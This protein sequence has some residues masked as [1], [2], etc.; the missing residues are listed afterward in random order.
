MSVCNCMFCRNKLT[1]CSVHT[2]VYRKTDACCEYT[3]VR[4]WLRCE[5]AAPAGLPAPRDRTSAR[6]LQIL[7]SACGK[8]INSAIASCVAPSQFARYQISERTPLNA[9]WKTY[10]GVGSPREVLLEGVA[11]AWPGPAKSAGAVR[12]TYEVR[13]RTRDKGLPALYFLNPRV[14]MRAWCASLAMC[15]C[16]L[17]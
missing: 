3:Y 17:A 7:Q 9:A 6:A 5:N 15:V 13:M 14:C 16:V 4:C 1:F 8:T 12:A 10:F 2:S 11:G